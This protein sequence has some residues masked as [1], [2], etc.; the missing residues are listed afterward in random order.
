MC[1]PSGDVTHIR[2]SK[3]NFRNSRHIPLH[4]LGKQQ[5]SS[6]VFVWGKQNLEDTSFRTKHCSSKCSYHVTCSINLHKT[7]RPN[8]LGSAS[9]L[10]INDPFLLSGGSPLALTIPG[11]RVHPPLVAH[12]VTDEVLSTS[13]DH[14][15]DA[16]LQHCGDGRV[17]ILHPVTKHV[18]V[19]G[20]AA[21]FPPA[22]TSNMFFLISFLCFL[23][24]IF[25][26][27]S[28]VCCAPP[29]SHSEI[30]L[31]ALHDMWLDENTHAP[32]GDMLAASRPQHRMQVLKPRLHGSYAYQQHMITIN[33]RRAMQCILHI[34]LSGLCIA[35]IKQCMWHLKH[36]VTTVHK[37]ATACYEAGSTT[38]GSCTHSVSFADKMH[39]MRCSLAVANSQLLP[40]TVLVDVLL[41][42]REVVTQRSLTLLADVVHIHGG[43]DS[44]DRRKLGCLAV[45]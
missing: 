9:R 30:S 23:S 4:I 21:L 22:V 36:L 5:L 13:I 41:Q 26:F 1:L 40:H 16:C 17:K 7:E 27:L 12:P 45:L 31:D 33:V 2:S 43:V 35:P 19:D 8:S 3:A 10:P 32:D 29:P 15:T 20:C 11:Q 25:Y 44:H 42:Q 6:C 38:D 34:A 14:D 24:L 18:K 28:L 39:E 37:I